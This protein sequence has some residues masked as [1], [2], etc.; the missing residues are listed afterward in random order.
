[1]VRSF[2]KGAG[3]E[4]G[5]SMK[6]C[7]LGLAV[8][9]S[10]SNLAFGLENK[11]F[12]LTRR[13]ELLHEEGKLRAYFIKKDPFSAVD[14]AQAILDAFQDIKNPHSFGSVLTMLMP[15]AGH[16]VETLLYENMQWHFRRLFKLEDKYIEN[17]DSDVLL[18][19]TK[20]EFDQKFAAL[21]RIETLETMRTA[22][23]QTFQVYLKILGSED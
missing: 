1:V 20:I 12:S 3:S 2:K 8:F 15:D 17:P 6:R 10:F 4:V 9:L 16:P 13:T 14:G 22:A 11:I 5:A 19:G 23:I 18:N 21:D 7:L